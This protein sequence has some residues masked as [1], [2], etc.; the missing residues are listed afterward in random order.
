WTAYALSDQMLAH[1][2]GAVARGLDREQALRKLQQ[3]NPWSPEIL[4]ALWHEQKR[5]HEPAAEATRQ[6]LLNLSPLDRE[7]LSAKN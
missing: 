6:Q 5:R 1:L 2:D 3:I 4:R 7:A